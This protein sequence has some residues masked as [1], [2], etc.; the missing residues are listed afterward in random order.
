M[1]ACRLRKIKTI[2]FTMLLLGRELEKMEVN[3]PKTIFCQK[4]VRGSSVQTRWR[5]PT[6]IQEALEKLQNGSLPLVVATPVLKQWKTKPL[7][8]N[9]TSHGVQVLSCKYAETSELQVSQ[10]GRF[11]P[12]LRCIFL[13]RKQTNSSS[14][15][16]YNS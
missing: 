6:L 4:L 11:S 16:E 1:Y 14:K 9:L 2:P 5:A 13:F 15:I 8:Y 3:R 7:S 10:P 12:D